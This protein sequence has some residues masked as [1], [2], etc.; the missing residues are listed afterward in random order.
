MLQFYDGNGWEHRA[1][2][3]EDLISL[4]NFRVG[5]LP[6]TSQWV[7]LEVPAAD[8]G[9]DGLTVSGIAFILYDGHAWFDRTGKYSRVNVALHKSA[10]QS[11]TLNVDASNPTADRA[12]DG[13]T[14]GNWSDL[15]IAHTAVEN[16]PWWQLDLG[17]VPP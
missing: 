10:T 14:S 13:N 2:W 3:G 9:L 8:V 11:S 4:A 7:R 16:Q 12:V 5:A 6:Q 1:I 15:S 17:S